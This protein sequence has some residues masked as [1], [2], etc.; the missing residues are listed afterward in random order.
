MS[1]EMEY[2]P[3]EIAEEI[4]DSAPEEPAKATEEKKQPAGAE[5]FEWLQ[6]VLMCVVCA[7]VAFNCVVRL[8]VVDGHSMDPTLEHG[9]LMLVWSLGYSPKQGDVVVLNKTTAGFLGEAAIV[10]RVI[11]LEGQ[12][13]D[14]DYEDSVVYVDGVALK[15]DYILEEMYLP[16]GSHMGQTHFEVPAGEIFVMG[17]N[18]N[19]STDSRDDRLGTVHEDYILGRAVAAIWPVNKI[20]LI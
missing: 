7:V 5:L 2:K 15:E 14:I 4:P 17:D 3:E 19:G 8:S 12:S 13:V 20:G 16:G 1:H 10:K 11:A 18:R 9:E 6:M